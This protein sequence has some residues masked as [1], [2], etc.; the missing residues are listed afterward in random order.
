M[1][2]SQVDALIEKANQQVDRVK[3][4]RRGERLYIRGRFPPKP[5]DG[6][7]VKRYEISTGYRAI[8]RELDLALGLAKEIEGQLV[9][10]RFDWA[11]YLKGKQKPAE[12]VAEWIE[13]LETDHWSLTPQNP[14]KLNSWK[15]NYREQLAKLPQNEPLTAALLKQTILERSEPGT[16][17]CAQWQ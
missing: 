15:K 3:I 10:E 9:R 17:S 13:R 4:L 6:T 14:T 16:R 8:R 12:T 7:E 11:P 1:D 5:G 2:Y